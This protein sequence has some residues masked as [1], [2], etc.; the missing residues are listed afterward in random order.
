MEQEYDLPIKLAQEQHQM[1]IDHY[2]NHLKVLQEQ[3]AVEKEKWKA[4]LTKLNG[5]LLVA[6]DCVHD[7]QVN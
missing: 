1:K 6:N 2:K 3:T 5:E 4:K 7:A